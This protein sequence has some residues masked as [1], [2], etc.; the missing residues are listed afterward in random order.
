MVQLRN[1]SREMQPLGESAYLF[2]NI[3]GVASFGAVEHES[4][5]AMRFP[6]AHVR[7]ADELMRDVLE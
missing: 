3:L 2:G 1:M 5:A 4:G 7:L 6:R